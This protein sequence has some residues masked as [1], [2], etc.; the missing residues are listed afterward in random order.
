MIVRNEEGMRATLPKTARQ[1]EIGIEVNGPEIPNHRDGLTH[2][3]LFLMDSIAPPLAESGK[4]GKPLDTEFRFIR[5][6]FVGFAIQDK[7]RPGDTNMRN[8]TRIRHKKLHS[9]R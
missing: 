4:S 5:F 7:L 8:A 9:V 3:N 2:Q 1:L 6:C